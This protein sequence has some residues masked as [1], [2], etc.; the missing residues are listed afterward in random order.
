MK[1][2]TAAAAAAVSATAVPRARGGVASHDSTRQQHTV[3]DS[4]NLPRPQ[5]RNAAKSPSVSAA[6]FSAVLKVVDP[7]WYLAFFAAAMATGAGCR[8]TKFFLSFSTTQVP[9]G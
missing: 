5:E 6:F 7:C 2:K 1:D 3:C 8:V 9:C 4:D